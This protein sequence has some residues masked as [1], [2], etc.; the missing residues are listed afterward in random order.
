MDKSR[1]LVYTIQRSSLDFVDSLVEVDPSIVD[2]SPEELLLLLDAL[3]DFWQFVKHLDVWIF[4]ETVLILKENNFENDLPKYQRR[5][6]KV[7]RRRIGESGVCLWK[8]EDSDES[9]YGLRAWKMK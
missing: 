8:A 1:C 4:L 5:Q 2:Q 6:G 9:F 3:L 7:R